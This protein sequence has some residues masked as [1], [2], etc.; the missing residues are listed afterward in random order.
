M[1]EPAATLG[2]MLGATFGSPLEWPSQDLIGYTD[3]FDAVLALEAYRCGVFPMPLGGHE[4]GWWSPMMRGLLPVGGLHITRSLRKSARRYRTTVDTAFNR[5]MTACADPG[6]PDGWI[7]ARIRAAY[8]RLHVEGWAHSVETWDEEGRLV[9]GLYGVH[10]AGLFAGESMFHH[11]EFGRDA[12]KVALMRLDEE[13]RGAGVVLLD[14]Q[15]LTDH[16]GTLGAYE[17]PRLEYLVKLDAALQLPTRPWPGNV[18]NPAQ[19][20]RHA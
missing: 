13:L 3:E 5:V 20:V 12:S 9:G 16:L 17:V 15:W 10:I 6:R 19:E 4:M 11:P 2:V 7:D 14:V 18:A 1:S 8:Q